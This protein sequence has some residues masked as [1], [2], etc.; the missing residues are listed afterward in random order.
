MSETDIQSPDELSADLREALHD[1]ILCLAD[2]KR[3]MGI[4]YADW[5]LGAPELEASIAA[6]SLAQDE[7]GHSRILYAMLK[8]FGTDPEKV[9]HERTPAEYRNVE[10]VDRPLETWPEFVVTNAVVDG[11]LTIQLEALR[12][13]R[14]ASLRQRMQKQLEEERFHEG[15]GIAWL[16]RLGAASDASR[17]AVQDA[18][19]DR[20]SAVLHWFGPDDFGA[21]GVAENLWG[22][23]GG[24]LRERFT[25]RIAPRLQKCGLQVPETELDFT[26]WDESARRKTRDGPDED[27]VARARGDKNRSMLLD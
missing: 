9:E 21:D 11:A 25:N 12:E 19:D 13:S 3:I 23:T 17:Q 7:W 15:H 2:S 14:Y 10:A 26:G 27:A 1:L 22:G 16:K 4:R 6:S 8:D 24:E 5:V 20:W 18:L